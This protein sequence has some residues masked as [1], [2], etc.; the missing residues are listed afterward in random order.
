MV[1]ASARINL[2]EIL[3]LPALVDNQLEEM[4]R[5]AYARALLL[6]GGCRRRCRCRRS[7][8]SSLRRNGESA[9]TLVPELAATEDL[10]TELGIFV[11]NFRYIVI[12][13]VALARAPVKRVFRFDRGRGIGGVFSG[14]CSLG[15]DEEESKNG[16]NSERIHFR[17]EVL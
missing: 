2:A 17:S 15:D 5:V 12:V 3:E 11:A 1:L 10:A 14:R 6:C 16:K 13:V 4:N 7:G 9:T 8:L